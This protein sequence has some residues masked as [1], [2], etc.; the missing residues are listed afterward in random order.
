[1][2]SGPD[3][4]RLLTIASRHKFALAG[5]ATGFFLATPLFVIVSLW[6][7]TGLLPNRLEL[8]KPALR[9]RSSGLSLVTVSA[10]G[11]TGGWEYELR[12]AALLSCFC[13]R[14][15]SGCMCLS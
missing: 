7:K 10:V 5:A 6:M 4:R 15:C 8:L 12:S 14:S 2:V 11:V 1:M 9:S 3:L 13:R